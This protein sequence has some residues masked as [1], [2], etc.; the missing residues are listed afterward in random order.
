MVL[1]PWHKGTRPEN[2]LYL[3][4]RPS[5]GYCESTQIVLTLMEKLSIDG[6]R[7]LNIAPDER[8]A[9]AAVKMGASRV[10]AKDWGPRRFVGSPAQPR[11]NDIGQSGT[12]EGN[13]LDGMEGLWTFRRTSHRP[14][15]DMLPSVPGFFGE[16]AGHSSPASWRRSGKPSAAL[17]NRGC[18][19]WTTDDQRLVELSLNGT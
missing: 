8:I 13:L 12:E 11:L 6:G 9:I 7:A 19:S 2:A 10:R 17:G 4:G 1:A 18:G 15:L 3:S 14:L 5:T 16:R